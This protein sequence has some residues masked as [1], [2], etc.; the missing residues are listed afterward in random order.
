MP[1]LSKSAKIRTGVFAFA[2][3]AFLSVSSF[4]GPNDSAWVDM[5]N[6]KDTS[7]LTN[8]DIKIRYSPMNEDT[9]GTFKRA[10]VGGDTVLEVNYSGYASFNNPGETH[11]NIGYKIR[12]FN[13]YIVRVEH[14]FWGTQA[15]S[16][17]SWA[18]Q[19]NGI[20]HH[21]QSIASFGLN[22]DFPISLEAQLLGPGNTGADN[23]SSMNL[24]TPGTAFYTTLTGGSVNTTHCV[25]A[26]T[27]DRGQALAPN[28]AWAK[29]EAYSDSVIKYYFKDS[30]VYTFYRPVEYAGNVA[31]N[32]QTITNNKP[33]KGGYIIL[34]GESA[35][36]RFRRVQVLNLE[37]CTTPTDL[38]YKTYFVKHDSAACGLPAGVLSRGDIRGASPMTF[39]GNSV[40]VGG[41]GMVTLEVFDL[42]GA[43]VARHTAQAPFQW[44]P[45]VKQAGMH[46]I[47]ALTPKGT[48]TEKATL[49]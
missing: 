41:Q 3:S 20:M 48:Y 33:I 2:A 4:A 13:Y 39:I 42:R 8:W 38:N 6:P 23:N 14:Q 1:A 7:L 47:R 40:K 21:S 5:F 36:T 27:K 31:N 11:G 30:L 28:W 44:T 37:G 46:V 15:P 18:V 10:I 22:Q 17:P 32:T 49:F 12:P 19:N 45:S 29:V 16:G 34:Q 24:C 9:R 35:P 26:A 43:R 25:S